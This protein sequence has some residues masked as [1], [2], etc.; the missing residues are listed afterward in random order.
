[1]HKNHF[2]A[3]KVRLFT[4][5]FKKSIP[6]NTSSAFQEVGWVTQSLIFCRWA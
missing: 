6:N 4:A 5:A 2:V 1:M 3:Q